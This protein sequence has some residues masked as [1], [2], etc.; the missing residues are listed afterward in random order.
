M[1]TELFRNEVVGF[2]FGFAPLIRGQALI[3]YR[4]DVATS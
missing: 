3:E 2:V 1:A 4:R